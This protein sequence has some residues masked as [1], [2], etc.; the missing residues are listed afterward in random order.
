MN[1]FCKMINDTNLGKFLFLSE[2]GYE[3]YMYMLLHSYMN[4]E[5]TQLR[6]FNLF[7]LSLE[8]LSENASFHKL[9]R[10]LSN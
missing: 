10:T 6:R 5:Y 3:T 1:W 8:N 9:R 4:S 7:N 2:L